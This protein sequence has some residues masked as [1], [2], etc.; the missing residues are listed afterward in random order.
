VDLQA[1]RLE[2]AGEVDVAF[3]VNQPVA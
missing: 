3:D 2:D 1:D